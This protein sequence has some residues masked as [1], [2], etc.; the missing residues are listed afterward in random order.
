MSQVANWNNLILADFAKGELPGSSPFGKGAARGVRSRFLLLLGLG[1]KDVK[2]TLLSIR[3][4]RSFR[5]MWLTKEVKAS[6]DSSD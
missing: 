4:F 3:S 1:D 2:E 6:S 5:S